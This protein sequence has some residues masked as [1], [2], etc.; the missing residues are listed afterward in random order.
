MDAVETEIFEGFAALRRLE[1]RVKAQRE[2][3]D[4]ALRRA[5]ATG[6]TWARVQELSGLSVRGVQLATK[7][8]MSGNS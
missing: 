6:H 8:V 5:L 3:T 2:Y 4:D 1:A 7:R